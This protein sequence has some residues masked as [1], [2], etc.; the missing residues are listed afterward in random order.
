MGQKPLLSGL[1]QYRPKV[2]AG[3]FRSEKRAGTAHLYGAPTRGDTEFVMLRLSLDTAVN[4]ICRMLFKTHRSAK[5]VLLAAMPD[6]G[7]EI[8]SESRCDVHAALEYE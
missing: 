2:F 5:R 1:E 7:V 3:A 4:V 8:S 6:G